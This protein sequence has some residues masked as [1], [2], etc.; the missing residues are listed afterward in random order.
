MSLTLMPDPL[1]THCWHE[2]DMQHSVGG[3]LHIDIHCCWCNK[4]ICHTMR[5]YRD[6]HHGTYTS[7]CIDPNFP[8]DECEARK[9]ST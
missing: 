1:K 3:G 5:P 7:D 8:T 9:C 2:N 6:P 4:Q